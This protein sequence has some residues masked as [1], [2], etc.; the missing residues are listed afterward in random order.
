MKILPASR[1][2]KF[3]FFVLLILLLIAGY[4]SNVQI[5]YYYLSYSPREGDVIFQSLPKNGLVDAIEGVTHS[6]YSHCGVVLRNNDR[7]VVIESIN[8]VHETPLFRWIQRGRG[9][10]FA[11]YRLKPEYTAAIPEFKKHLL[12]YLGIPYD[13]DYEISDKAIYCSELVYKAFRQTNREEMGTLEKLG[14]LNW[15]PYA[16]FIKSVQANNLPLDR[17]MITPRSL[18]EA[19]QLE[20]VTS[21]GL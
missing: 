15:K 11:V 10:G 5:L 16:D 8:D 1:T 18:S 9:A 13:Y 12:E 14:T 2:G 17:V 19:P 3:R 4:V 21:K 7:W 6:P 20:L